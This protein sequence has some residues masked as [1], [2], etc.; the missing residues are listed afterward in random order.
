MKE[1]VLVLF[2]I[3]FTGEKADKK[4]RNPSISADGRFVAFESEEKN[5]V[6]GG[7]KGHRRGVY[8]YD[9]VS[10][11]VVRMSD[12][13][14]DYPKDPVISPDGRFVAFVSRSRH[15][16]PGDG[17]RSEQVFVT[18][19]K[20]GTLVKRVSI[21]SQ[22]EPGDR[23]SKSPLLSADGRFVVF[24]SYASNL[25]PN[26]TNKKKGLPQNL[27]VKVGQLAGSAISLSSKKQVRIPERI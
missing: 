18:E 7:D 22:G 24:E 25:V 17:K 9:R 27:W 19:W 8:I 12:T 6:P 20:V 11:E 16:A 13:A 14:D 15:L 5:L 1:N 3:P 4:S 2:R 21:S 26:D 23:N 10:G